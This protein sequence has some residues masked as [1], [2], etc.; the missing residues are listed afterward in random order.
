MYIKELQEKDY[1]NGKQVTYE[2][3][4]RYCYTV[5]KTKNGENMCF[6]LQK[7]K[8]NKTFHKQLTGNL[9]EYDDCNYYALIE[10]GLEMGVLALSFQEWNNSIVVE[11][12][13]INRNSQRQGLGKVFMD[14]IKEQAISYNARIIMLETQTMNYPAIQFYKKNGFEIIGFNLQSYSNC[15]LEN[16][17]VRLEMGYK[18]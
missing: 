18:I 15:D 17:E 16:N 10:N 2:Y 4:T 7:I 9:F 6:E 1:P 5:K 11:E 14:Y 8:L 13:H 12:I 3:T